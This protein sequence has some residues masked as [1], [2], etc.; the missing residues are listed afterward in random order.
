MQSNSSFLQNEDNN[1]DNMTFGNNITEFYRVLGYH[2]PKK[3]NKMY[4]RRLKDTK[5]ALH[6][7]FRLEQEQK[8]NF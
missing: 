3:R 6:L 5:A 1:R 2:N 4:L 8:F 7:N